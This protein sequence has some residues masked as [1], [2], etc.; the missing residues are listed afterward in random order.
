MITDYGGDCGDS[1]L[2]ALNPPPQCPT[3]GTRK[4]NSAVRQDL[5]LFIREP[6]DLGAELDEP[7]LRPCDA[8]VPGHRRGDDAL[9]L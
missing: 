7:V 8:P 3:I 2:N 6:P 4:A 1:Y 5:R 9:C